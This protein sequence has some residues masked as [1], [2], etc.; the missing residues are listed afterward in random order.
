[1][2]M[3]QLLS[4][5]PMY[6]YQLVQAIK[7]ASGNQLE[8]GEGSIYPILH[9]LEADGCLTSREI[10]ANGRSRVVYRTTPKGK[11]RLAASTKTWEDIAKAIREV[12]DSKQP[13]TA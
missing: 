6:G 13:L 4:K 8:F 2:L 12:L 3:L 11:K 10:T 5:E 9:R 1:M 7:A